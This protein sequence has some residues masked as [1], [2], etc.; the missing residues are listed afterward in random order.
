MEDIERYVNDEEDESPKASVIIHIHGNVNQILPNA[1]RSEQ[2]YY[3]DR[4]IE[5]RLS[6]RDSVAF[7]DL[8]SADVAGSPL[9][10]YIAEVEVLRDY[11]RKLADCTDAKSVGRMVVEMVKDSSVR[12]DK[13]M[14]VKA[15]FIERLK[16]M[17]V[18]L[19]H[20]TGTDNLRKYINQ[21]WDED[22]KRQRL[23]GNC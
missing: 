20:G 10:P 14:M 1:T 6:G 7:R 21:A 23:R 17:L 22:R 16:P 11:T 18:N 9:L 15:S 5:E 12:I 19:T 13:D 2:I 8:L 4:Y 3:S